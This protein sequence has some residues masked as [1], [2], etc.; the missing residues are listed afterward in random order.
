MAG[1]SSESLQEYDRPMVKTPIP[2]PRSKV[3]PTANLQF[4]SISHNMQKQ[5][6]LQKI[7]NRMNAFHKTVLYIIFN[8]IKILILSIIF[9]TQNVL[10]LNLLYVLYNFSLSKIT[11]S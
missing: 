6:W 3:P 4:F 5:S 8:N 9:Q 2:G 10:Y 7:S 1:V 11:S